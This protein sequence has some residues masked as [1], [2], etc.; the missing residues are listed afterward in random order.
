M[1]SLTRA[2]CLL[3]TAMMLFTFACSKSVEGESQRWT[4]NAAR[5]TE[6][7]AL[8]PGFKPALQA[9]QQ[10]AQQIFDAAS[11]LGDEQKIAKLSEASGA[12]MAGFVGDLDDIDDKMKKLRAA[13][14]DV[15]AKVGDT[16]R[17]GAEVAAEEAQKTLERVE[18][19]LKSGATDEASAAAIVRQMKADL[20]AAQAVLDKLL[21]ADKA[22]KSDAADAKKDAEAAK[23]DAAAAAEAKVAPWKCAYCSSENPHDETSCKSCGAPKAS[24]DQPAGDKPE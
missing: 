12:L 11:G 21:A 4:T 23:K 13:R 18:A 8:Y 9:R 14:V 22:K 24:G 3:L 2:L 6:L 17:L 19:T 5:V 7:G 1:Q 15:A 20:D 16:S 10:A